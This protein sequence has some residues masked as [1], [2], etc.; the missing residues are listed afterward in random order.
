MDGWMDGSPSHELRAS[1]RAKMAWQW[2]FLYV[3]Y[4]PHSFFKLLHLRV[5]LRV[6]C[7]CRQVGEDRI[8]SEAGIMY[9]AREIGHEL[10]KICLPLR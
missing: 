8:G 7:C 10:M 2:C 4:P 6:P 5:G 9:L 3:L 1:E